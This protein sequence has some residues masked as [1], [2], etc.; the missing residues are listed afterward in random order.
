[1]LGFIDWDRQNQ[2]KSGGPCYLKIKVDNKVHLALLD[3]GCSTTLIPGRFARRHELRKSERKCTAAN[4]TNIPI[5]GEVDLPVIIGS[6]KT[7]I[8]GLVTDFVSEVMISLEWL[9]ENR[10]C[11][12]FSTG[13]V[14]INGTEHQLVGKKFPTSM[15]RRVILSEDV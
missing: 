13:T 10:A 14:K 6:T 7:V 2:W 3:T 1:M 9:K 5:N 15:C 12:D 11:W 8:T 4:G